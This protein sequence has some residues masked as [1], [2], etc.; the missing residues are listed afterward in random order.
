MAQE[1]SFQF[2]LT[3]FRP[4]GSECKQVWEGDGLHQLSILTKLLAL[5]VSPGNSA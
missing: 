4:L 3:F 5:G 2:R 1:S